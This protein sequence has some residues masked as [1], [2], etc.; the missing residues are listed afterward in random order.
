MVERLAFEWVLM[1]M[2]RRQRFPLNDVLQQLTDDSLGAVGS[3]DDLGMDS[4]SDF[5]Y[6]SPVEGIIEW[7]TSHNTKKI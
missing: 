1:S 2:A 5:D 3:D 7:H 6:D 4:D